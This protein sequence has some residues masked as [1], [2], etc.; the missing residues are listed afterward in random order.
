MTINI[1]I[2]DV[3]Q[4]LHPKI[5]VLGVG[6]SGGNAVNNMINANLEGVD[7]LI[8]NTDAQALQI[9]SCPNKIQLGLNSTKGLGAGLRPDIGRQA[10]EEAIQDLSEKFEGSHMLFIAAG[11]GGGTGTGAAPVIASI[12]KELGALTVAVVTKPF[13]FEGK[14][15]MGAAEKGLASLVEEVD[16]LVTI[17][18]EKLFEILGLDTS[19]QDAFAKS[20]DVLKG[21]VQGIS[22]IIM[23]RGHVNVDF[24]DVKAVMSEKGIAMMGTGIASGKNRAEAAASMAV[25]SELLDDINLKNARGVLVNITGKEPT[26]RDQA[27][28]ADIIDE[29]VCEDA[30]IIYGLVF[31]KNYK[32]EIKVTIVATGVDQRAPSLV[33]DNEPSI[34]LNPVGL[35]KD[36][37]N[38]KVGTSS[39]EEIDFLD[40]PT[41]MRKQV[42]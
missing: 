34:K 31:D 26:L 14:K 20:D 16:S 37:T 35:D 2:Q 32:D 30:N 23:Q 22:D 7:F 3:E 18:N 40:V 19:I 13:K 41:F 42:D 10:A 39:A 8:A 33:I 17:P 21:A 24:A 25:K 11:M 15:R 5:T 6:G 29:I 27:E 38:Q 1:S 4:N 36:K 12:A 9:S 28:V